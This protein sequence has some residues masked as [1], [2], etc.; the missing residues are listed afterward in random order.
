M[1]YKRGLQLL[2]SLAL[3]TFLT[4]C[5]SQQK[6]T[7][8][9][10]SA[11]PFIGGTNALSASFLPGAPPDY[12]FD[13][14]QYPFGISVHLENLGEH[15]VG[16]ADGYVEIVGINPKDFGLNTQADLRK[17][18]TDI[19][20]GAK[21]N[22]AGDVIEGGRTIVSFGDTTPLN[23]KPD[24]T[25]N[26]DMTLRANLCYD[27]KTIA[28]SKLCVKRDLL[29]NIQTKEICDVQGDKLVVNSGAPIQIISMSQNPIGNNKIQVNFVVAH[30][31]AQNDRFFK[32]DTV[33]DDKTTNLNKDIVYVNI[34]SDINGNKA[35]CSGL[36]QVNADG[37]AGY[38]TLF[39]GAP[40]NVVCTFDVSG[41]DFVAQIPLLV[42]LEYRY[43]QFIEVPVI[44]Q[45]V[46]TN[47]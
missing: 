1:R 10:P 7:Q 42:E 43:F 9:G 11:T 47:G 5:A 3:V 20:T 17:E 19:L 39:N 24:I 4:A 28:S 37:N 38:I 21:K 25:G 34:V 30:V 6:Q 45:D 12:I 15:D 32:K 16:P 46:T 29:T 41:I 14:G 22:F 33:C 2:I 13:K 40:R 36:Q 8:T 27:Y 31:G 23:Y 18:F 26:F 35:K 44:I